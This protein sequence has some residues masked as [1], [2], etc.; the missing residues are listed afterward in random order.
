MCSRVAKEVARVMAMAA[1]HSTLFQL[2]KT[3]RMA[4]FI[5]TL[6]I[7]TQIVPQQIVQIN[8]FPFVDACLPHLYQL[9]ENQNIGVSYTPLL[10]EEVSEV[11]SG[12][13]NPIHLQI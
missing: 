2:H 9:K 3:N 6:L 10:E 11:E 13:F 5:C 12:K 1:H 4:R 8:P 7:L